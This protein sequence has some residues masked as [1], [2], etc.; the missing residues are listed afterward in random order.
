MKLEDKFFKS[1]FYSFFASVIACTFVVTTFLGLFTNTYYD[2]KSYNYIRDLEKNYSKIN[3]NSVNIILTSTI[4]R[5]QASLNEH[6]LHYQKLANK[7][8][9]ETEIP[10][11]NDTYMKC[12]LTTSSMICF[13]EYEECDKY[14]LWSLDEE[15]NEYNLDSKEDAKKQII[16]F[17]NI[18]QNMNTTLEV[19]KPN[20]FSYSFYFE[21]NEL[22]FSFPIKKLCDSNS[23]YDI[24]SVPYSY[25]GSNCVNEKGEFYSV[26]KYKCD[27]I[28]KNFQKSK[29]N[30]FD[31]NYSNERNK[32]IFISNYYQYG[33]EDSDSKFTMCIEFDDPITK[34]KGYC[35]TE[36]RTDDMLVSLENLNTNII[37][38]Y[39]ITIVGFKNVFYFPKGPK[40]PLTITENIFN[41]NVKFFFDEKTFFY[42]NINNIF[43]SNY[44]DF[45]K[46]TIYDEV[47]VNGKNTNMQY[48]ILNGKKYKY[49]IYPVVLEN[50]YEEKE[51]VFSIIYIYNDELFF[52]EVEN[53][54]NIIIIQIVLE[55]IIFIIFG[56]GLLY[57]ICLTFNA[58]A[59]YIVIPIKN[60]NYMLNGINIGG[61]NRLEY[62]KFLKKR[63]DENLEILE[64]IYLLENK[65]NKNLKE[66]IEETDVDSSNN[67]DSNNKIDENSSKN[68]EIKN[69]IDKTINKYKYSDFD[70]IYDKESSFIENE[71]N[72][73]DFD[74]Q[75]LQYRNFEMERLVKFLIDLKGSLILTSQDREVE[76]LID[77]SHSENIFRNLNNKKGAIICQS[78]IGNL[79]SQLLQY[80]K[81]IY[82]LVLSLQDSQLKKFLKRNII[83]ELDENNT[84]LNTLYDFF[85]KE[86]DKVKH[87][88]LLERQLNKSKDCLPQEIIGIMINTRYCRL[89]QVYYKFFKNLQ[90][91]KKS[92]NYDLKGQ[93]MNIAFHTIEYYHKILIQYIYLSYIKKD[94]VKI[95]ESTLDYIEF[96]IKFKFKTSSDDKYFLEIKHK[97]SPESQTK[98]NMK[99]RI[100]DKILDW[101]DLFDTYS[102][103]IKNNSTLGDNKSII[104][105]YT[106]GLKSEN[107][108]KILES[109]SSFLF[110]ISIQKSEFLKG[111]FCLYCKN[112]NDALFYFIR[113]AKKKSIVIDGLI[114]KKSLRHIN[115]IL[116]KMNKKYNKFGLNNLN[117]GKEIENRKI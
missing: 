35:C 27:F 69:F 82:H 17:S 108:E 86:K 105:A 48:F 102:S 115:K 83:D 52:R 9:E 63:Q 80:D 97:N 57:L 39:F 114:K 65:K 71:L 107:T 73:Y 117:I 7:L 106:R 15:T 70:K 2:K 92:K 59:K 72:F 22:F 4:E 89:I 38:Y 55:L 62:L 88:K 111:K 87:N 112:Y 23:I 100:F 101:F 66:S 78:N 98:L 26:Y 19:G 46:K 33:T 64:K 50:L 24:T 103:Y 30:L 74:E 67:N 45:M 54:N 6:I 36:Y 42:D 85:N 37:G 51:H 90:K 1:F 49:S 10:E 60:V 94:L 11:V 5:V 113:A 110:K 95:G 91:L 34:G 29:S 99:K 16:A 32:T 93:F 109:E 116:I 40:N 76:R 18:I 75:L 53:N 68:T 56:S 25:D 84:L 31:N 61:K 20:S 14:G 28:F 81:A 21:K 104:D 44:I 3:I 13:F 96:L 58:L 41:W 43:S 12:A 47:Y 8:L 79:Q 77:F